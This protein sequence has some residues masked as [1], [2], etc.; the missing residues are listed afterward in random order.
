[1]APVKTCNTCKWGIFVT[2]KGVPIVFKCNRYPQEVRKVGTDT[3]GE[4]QVR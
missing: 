1:M 3:C 4:Y 2:I